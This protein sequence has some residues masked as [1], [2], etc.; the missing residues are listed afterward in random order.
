MNKQLPTGS[1][2]GAY[3]LVVGAVLAMVV[4][5]GWGGWVT[6]GT[7]DKMAGARAQAAVVQAFT[8]ICVANAQLEPE[9][10]ALLKAE[11][12]W[13]RDRFVEKA[14]WADGAGTQYR[15]GVAGACAKKA[16]EAVE[17]SSVK[18]PS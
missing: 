7:A 8:P 16:V 4:G 14:G 10:L 11:S 9:K 3:G 15:D 5:F 6:G 2:Y 13:S 1:K 17:A 12:S 18:K